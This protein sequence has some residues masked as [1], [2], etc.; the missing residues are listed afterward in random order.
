MLIIP[1][2]LNHA[3]RATFD[4]CLAAVLGSPLVTPEQDVQDPADCWQEER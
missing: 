4:P 1:T 2:P 3:E